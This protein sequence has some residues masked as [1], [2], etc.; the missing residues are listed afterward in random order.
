MLMS[1]NILKNTGSYIICIEI[2]VWEIK[3]KLNQPF[4]YYFISHATLFLE[5]KNCCENISTCFQCFTYFPEVKMNN[6]CRWTK[7]K[8]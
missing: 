2:E 1:L 5:V 8:D 4:T 3:T 7:I 6:A